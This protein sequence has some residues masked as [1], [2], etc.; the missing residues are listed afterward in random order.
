MTFLEVSLI[1]ALKKD[2]EV[3]EISDEN[4]C[5]NYR[6]LNVYGE[7]NAIEKV[8]EDIK[9]KGFNLGDCQ[10][11]LTNTAYEANIK[12]VLESRNIN[13][14]YTSS[15][16]QNASGL[17]F[18]NSYL[19]WVI[20]DFS[21]DCFMKIINADAMLT[22]LPVIASED[23]SLSIYLDQVGIDAGI[24]YGIDRYYEFLHKIED[25]GT[26]HRYFKS[27]Y[28]RNPY[29]KEDMIIDEAFDI[30]SDYLEELL[31]IT[32]DISIYLPGLLLERIVDFFDYN[33]SYRE[34]E[35]TLKDK[36]QP[37]ID[38][39]KMMANTKS[40]KESILVIEDKLKYLGNADKLENN[41][42]QVSTL[43]S[44]FVFFR[45]NI[46]IIGMNYDDFEPKLRDNP[47]IS[48]Y[49][50]RKCLDESY[51][52]K[53]SLNTAKEKKD[54]LIKSLSTFSGNQITFIMSNYNTKEFRETIPSPIYNELKKKYKEEL[55][56]GKYENLIYLKS[57]E[58]LKYDLEKAVRVKLVKSENK[59]GHIVYRL[60]KP[61]TASQLNAIM[62]CPLQYIYSLKY[63]ADD[64]EKRN[65]YEWLNPAEKG[66][67]FHYV[68]EAYCK[69]IINV[70]SSDLSE[71]VYLDRFEK[72]FDE[73]IN[74]FKEMV[75]Y[76][77][78]KVFEMEKQEYHDQMLRYLEMMH[79]EFKEHHISVRKVEAPFEPRITKE[80][81][82]SIDENG[83]KYS[84]G[85]S[86]ELIISF[87]AN[88]TIDR[89]D[90]LEVDE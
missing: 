22:G 71:N 49:V 51:Y 33:Q 25:V 28:E 84:S 31:H 26:R 64:Y 42:I 27:L 82:L 89:E 12:S 72:I 35:A 87:K 41:S 90:Y 60:V 24:S 56:E 54:M 85:S 78:E 9:E 48:N 18:I 53:L 1:N 67:L 39:L 20:S 65:P 79:S 46:Y 88:T 6:L 77:N 38:A 17:D 74:Y 29:F 66:N 75:V 80:R 58:R 5:D 81:T 13:Y 32:E 2:I 11:L 52:I 50:L 4:K 70:K 37:I 83:N 7:A 62:K 30:I 57:N 86:E 47:I 15:H 45:N 44:V 23:L 73:K 43:N 8:L 16:K 55:C 69:T 40:I 21:Y 14:S 63:F 3:I 34:N 59:S 76:P 10:I 36:M 68:F 61:L 19:Q